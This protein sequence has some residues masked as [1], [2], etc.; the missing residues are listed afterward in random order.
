MPE[1]HTADWKESVQ[2]EFSSAHP[3]SITL[4]RQL[5]M[6]VVSFGFLRRIV[7]LLAT[8]PFPLLA[9][10]DCTSRATAQEKKVVIGY[11]ARDFNNFP[12]L[13]AEANGYFREAGIGRSSS[14][15]DPLS[16]CPAF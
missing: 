8:M 5:H 9:A 1:Q 13:L 4:P 6:S 11:V 3:Q 10:I 7:F 12:P 2:N 15:S 14:R 16:R